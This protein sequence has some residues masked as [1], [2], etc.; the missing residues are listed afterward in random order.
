MFSLLCSTSTAQSPPEFTPNDPAYDATWAHQLNLP[1]AWFIENQLT[2]IASEVDIVYLGSFVDCSK[3]DIQPNCLAQLGQDFSGEAQFNNGLF[4]DTQAV[5]LMIAVLNNGQAVPGIAGM[6][7]K[8]KVIPDK[9]TDQNGSSSFSKL[10]QGLQHAISL[11]DQG[12]PVHLVVSSDVSGIDNNLSAT[13]S[14]LKQMAQRQIEYIAYA[15]ERG[16]DLD[17][18]QNFCPVCYKA[19]ADNVLIVAGSDGNSIA[20]FSNRG[21]TTV[22][23]AAQAVSVPVYGILDPNHPARATGGNYATAQAAGVYSLI[24]MYKTSNVN[25]AMNLLRQ[26]ARMTSGLQ[27]NVTYG[28]PDAY[29]ALSFGSYPNGPL[30]LV[31][32]QGGNQLV[33]VESPRF[34]HGPFSVLTDSLFNPDH[35]TRI[36]LVA[37]NLQ[38]GPSDHLS[39]VVVTAKDSTNNNYNLPVE[40]V[41]VIPNFFGFSQLVVRL[42]DGLATGTLNVSITFHNQTSNSGSITIQ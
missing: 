9:I 39:D 37:V 21:Q 40:D 17:A 1:A 19:F 27:G 25:S 41:R 10:R 31:I 24:V 3:P 16:N 15:G 12:H 29:A 42:P 6:S 30:Q 7:G 22:D 28:I 5:G 8:I 18:N 13:V 11:V 34:L 4:F 33:A 38:L 23:L 32:Q 20:G 2:P 36:M 26:T 14:L 35:H